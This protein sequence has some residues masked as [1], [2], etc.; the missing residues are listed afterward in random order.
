MNITTD[1]WIEGVNRQGISGGSEM[2][3]RRCVVIHFTSGA[4]AMSSIDFWRTAAAKG[5]SAHIII[6]RDGTI[7]QCRPFNRTCGH[8]G[9]SKW[10][11]PNTGNAYTGLNSCSIGIELANAGNDTAV[12]RI[13]ARLP[14]YVGVL[15]AKHRNGGPMEPW[16]VYPDKQLDACFAVT[17]ALVKRYKLDDITGHDCI[18]PSR[19]NDPGPL[20]QMLEL[21]EECGF[22]GLPVVHR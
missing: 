17:L 18:A 19:K 1:H 21:R 4:T 20:F 7:Y 10:K 5:A 11:D 16:E 3:V 15:K 14:G 22:T 6:D 8:A 9:V 13:A 12:Q 2:P